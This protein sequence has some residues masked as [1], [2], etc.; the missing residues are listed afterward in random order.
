MSQLLS[1]IP[2]SSIYEGDT[3]D[4]FHFCFP[5]ES[6]LSIPEP[7]GSQTASVTGLDLPRPQLKQPPPP[8]P[9]ILQRVGPDRYKAYVLYPH[10]AMPRDAFVTWWLKTD[11]GMEKR[12]NW[13]TNHQSE[14]WKQFEQ[15]ADAKTGKPAVMCKQCV[16]V[17][18]HPAT[19]RHGTSSMNKHIKGVNC[20]KA[21]KRPNIKQALENA[22]YLS[23]TLLLYLIYSH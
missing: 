14:C 8:I 18:E 19:C 2:S 1:N 21:T 20:R 23:F 10:D 3:S 11:Y 6:H 17:L 5:D 7:S 22:V 12:I 13:D 16:A 4:P 9:D 15:V